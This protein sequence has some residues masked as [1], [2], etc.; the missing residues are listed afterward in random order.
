M[1]VGQEAFQNLSSDAK[2]FA[3]Q[4]QGDDDHYQPV[5]KRM[6][7]MPQ[8]L[9]DRLVCEVTSASL[10]NEITEKQRYKEVIDK[11]LVEMRRRFDKTNMSLMKAVQAL[12]PHSDSFLL[13]R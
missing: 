3:S 6:R 9:Q 4:L 11:I 5:S 7:R 2:H 8:H 1:D 12:L 10:S 13:L